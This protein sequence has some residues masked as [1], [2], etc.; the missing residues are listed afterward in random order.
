[1]KTI[2]ARYIG[3]KIGLNFKE[4]GKFHQIT[5]VDVQDDHFSVRASEGDA[6]AHYPFWQVLSF[7]ESAQ[8]IAISGFGI[9]HGP[10]VHFVV[11]THVMA[12]GSIG[13]IF[14]V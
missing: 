14:S 10:K 6:I 7:T 1:V 12:S 5:L 9:L 3:Q 13:F 11:Q 8:G 4:I 2:F